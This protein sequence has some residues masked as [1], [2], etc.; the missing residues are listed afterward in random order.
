MLLWQRRAGGARGQV[1][2]HFL[3]TPNATWATAAL[4]RRV[5]DPA[6][7][8]CV[9]LVTDERQPLPLGR[10][11]REYLEELGRRGPGQFR[12]R[13]IPFADYAALDAL[14]AVVGLA[15]SGDLEVEF[16]PGRRRPVSEAEVIASHHRRQ[17]YRA[18]P[19]LKELLGGK[20]GPLAASAA[21]ATRAL[22]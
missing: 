17:R 15:R 13:E 21:P 12:L 14:Q 20:D 2:V 9:L 1:G 22:V 8:E 7:R 16:P 6:R 18:L 10:R 4:R 5:E 3:T 19:L 11:G